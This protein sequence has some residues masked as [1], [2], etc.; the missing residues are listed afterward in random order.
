[1]LRYLQPSSW[2]FIFMALLLGLYISSKMQTKRTP[3]LLISPA[4][5]VSYGN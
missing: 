2:F 1:M 3:Q 5:M 4:S